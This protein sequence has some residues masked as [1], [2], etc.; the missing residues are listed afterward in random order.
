[1]CDKLQQDGSTSKPALT[2]MSFNVEGFTTNKGDMLGRMCSDN[3]CDVLCMQETHRD[4]MDCRPKIPGMKLVLELPDGRY[5]SAIFIKP[6]LVIT[7]AFSS[8]MNDTEIITVELGKCTITSIYKPPNKP[9]DFKSPS[10][11]YNQ[12][13][14]F[15]LGDFNSHSSNWGYTL[16]DENGKKVEEWAE[17]EGLSLIHDPKL[18]CSF[19]SG[20]WKRGY[21]PHLIFASERISQQCIKYM[22]Q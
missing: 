22:S 4:T 18:P 5:G 7:S 8:R 6:E 20:R 15:V 10:N 12:D 21:N 14:R 13:I 11:F 2:I 16:T 9:F 3:Q 17:S 1:M 19:N